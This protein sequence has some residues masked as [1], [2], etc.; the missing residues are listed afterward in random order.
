MIRQRIGSVIVRQK[1]VQQVLGTLQLLGYAVNR[2]QAE[3]GEL[4]REGTGKRH[5]YCVVYISPITSAQKTPILDALRRAAGVALNDDLAG[6]WLDVAALPR[7]AGAFGVQA[8]CASA[9]GAAQLCLQ[10]VR[11]ALQDVGLTLSRVRVE[12]EEA[13]E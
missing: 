12:V 5:F 6:K 2:I 8:F 10:L 13:D 1:R 3:L 11:T 4:Q 7:E 9:D